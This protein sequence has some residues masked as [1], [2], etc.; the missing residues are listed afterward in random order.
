MGAIHTANLPQLFSHLSSEVVCP[1]EDTSISKTILEDQWQTRL[2]VGCEK[3]PA[4]TRLMNIECGIQHWI[5]FMSY[6]NRF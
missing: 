3:G 2:T 5:V 6:R 1:S 4:A